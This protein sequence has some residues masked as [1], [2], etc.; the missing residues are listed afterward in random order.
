MRRNMQKMIDEYKRRFEV[1]GN[2]GRGQFFVSDIL[3]LIEIGEREGGCIIDYIYSA[4]MA[5][6]MIG[7]RLGRKDQKEGRR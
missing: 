5:G 2:H 4:I 3:Q 7:Y 6:F 1:S